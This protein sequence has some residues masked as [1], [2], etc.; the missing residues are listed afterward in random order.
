MMREYITGIIKSKNTGKS[1]EV[2]E[3]E[4]EAKIKEIPRKKVINIESIEITNFNGFGKG[5]EIEYK[6][7]K[8]IIQVK[9]ENGSGKTGCIVDALLYGMYDGKAR[10][11]DNI[12]SKTREMTIIVE[13]EENG[14][15][16][17]IETEAQFKDV[18]RN[19]KNFS[20]K[21]TLTRNNKRIRRDSVKGVKDIITN[22]VGTMEEMTNVTIIS[23]DKT[24]LFS[25]MSDTDRRKIIMRMFRI[26]EYSN[27]YRE[28]MNDDTE[29]GEEI[30]IE[31]YTRILKEIVKNINKINE[32]YIL[33]YENKGGRI[34]IYAEYKN[35]KIE[36]RKLG[37]NESI[38][39]EIM[40]KVVM[41]KINNVVETNILVIDVPNIKYDVVEKIM[42]MKEKII[43]ITNDDIK[44]DVEIGIEINDKG[45][46]CIVTKH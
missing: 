1:E 18:F 21:I 3:E 20:T 16:Y 44:H 2:I 43:I 45:E 14:D 37:Y 13:M 12:N 35:K 27:I 42:D 6:N 39:F 46:S 40:F 25:M 11:Y 26:E 36:I 32:E 30:E 29:I 33:K 5:N 23:R 28:V 17:V 4:Y 34:S 9:G 8:G 38:K 41:N 7:M 22:T 10:N 19:T 24:E 15:K 31:L